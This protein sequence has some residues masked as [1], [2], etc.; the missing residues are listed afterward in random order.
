LVEQRTFNPLANDAT[1]EST[2]KLQRQAKIL[3]PDLLAILGNHPE[4]L[5]VIA[6]WPTLSDE[7]RAAVLEVIDRKV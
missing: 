7:Q 3:S 5:R 2:N 6:A 1:H 4:L